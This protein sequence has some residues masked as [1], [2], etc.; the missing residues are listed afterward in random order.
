[1]AVHVLSDNKNK[2]VSLTALDRCDA[3]PAQAYV[4]VYGISGELMFCS[5]HYN[6]IMND[7]KGKVALD[8]FAFETIDQRETLS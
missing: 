7:P 3:C 6:K 8:S 2:K 1:M 4:L 5:H